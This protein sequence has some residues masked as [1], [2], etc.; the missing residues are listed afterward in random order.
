MH[1]G[2]GVRLRRAKSKAIAVAT[3]Q[4]QREKHELRPHRHVHPEWRQAMVPENIANI[5]SSMNMPPFIEVSAHC[6]WRVPA[7]SREQQLQEAES[8]VRNEQQIARQ[9]KLVSWAEFW[10]T[11]TG[12]DTSLQVSMH[13]LRLRQC[14]LKRRAPAVGTGEQLQ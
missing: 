9:C 1:T 5:A 12:A 2:S 6:H 11:Q 10:L 13:I 3:Q 7:V 14:T 8:R 4:G